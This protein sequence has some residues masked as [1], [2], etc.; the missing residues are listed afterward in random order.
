MTSLAYIEYIQQLPPDV[1]EFCEILKDRQADYLVVF[2]DFEMYLCSD[3]TE[4][5]V[6][7]DNL[8]LKS[9]LEERLTKNW[10]R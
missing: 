1:I 9:L 4:K 3:C 6:A 2:K 10:P 7:I 5:V 8:I